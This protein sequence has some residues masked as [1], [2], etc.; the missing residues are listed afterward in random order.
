[1]I[2]ALFSPHAFTLYTS[3]S[4][5][6]PLLPRRREAG[7]GRD[8]DEEDERR[9]DGG[10]PQVRA[11]S[12]SLSLSR[13]LFHTT[14]QHFPNVIKSVRCFQRTAAF[15]LKEP[16]PDFTFTLPHLFSPLTSSLFRLIAFEKTKPRAAP[17]RDA[18]RTACMSITRDSWRRASTRSRRCAGSAGWTTCST[19]WG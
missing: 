8:E 5:P 1:M 14:G 9:H 10:V 7:F 12:P 13:S 19:L 11:S 15:N 4:A 16:L 3:L 2:F 17:P 6:L 18:E